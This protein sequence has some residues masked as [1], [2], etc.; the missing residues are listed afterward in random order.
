MCD[1][2]M[3]DRDR[4]RENEEGKGKKEVFGF[5][6]ED[7]FKVGTFNLLIAKYLLHNIFVPLKNIWHFCD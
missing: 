6:K 2:Y 5:L 1:I 4:E 7:R 3:W